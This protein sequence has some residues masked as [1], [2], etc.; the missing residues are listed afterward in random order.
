MAALVSAIADN[1]TEVSQSMD[2]RRASDAV[3]E[4]SSF[5]AT[6]DPADH[7]YSPPYHHKDVDVQSPTELRS[8]EYRQLFRLPAEEVL[9]QDFNCAFQENILLQGHMYL[10]L[11]H[12]CFYSN[13]FGFETKKIIPFHEVTC[14]RRAKTAGIFP[15][16]I[17]IFAGGKKHFF[18]SFLSRDEA[19][20]I[21][22]DGWLQHGNGANEGSEQQDSISETS[23]ENGPIVI[24]NVKS[25][26]QPISNVESVD[27]NK[28]APTLADSKL[29][30]NLEGDVVSTPL[31]E[32]SEVLDNV[33][34]EAVP[35]LISNSS[36]SEKTSIWKQENSDAPKIP[37]YY[38]R[39]AESKFPIKVEEFFSLF[40][41]DEAVIFGDSF[42]KQCGDKD[43]KCTPWYPHE[44]FGHA[45]EVSFQHPI[46]LYFGAKF[47]SCQEVQKFRVYKNSHLIIETSQEIN[48]VPYG[49]Y[50]CVEGLWDVERDGDETKESCVLRVYVNVAFSKRTVWKG[51]IVQSTVEECREAYGT[52]LNI[53]HELLKQKNLEK[54]E[55]DQV[56]L[57]RKK[58]EKA[59]CSESSFEPNTPIPDS[60]EFKRQDSSLL[61]YATPVASLFKESTMKSFASLKSQSHFPLL[62]VITFAVILVMMQLSIVVLLTRPQQVHV[63]SQVDYMN[64]MGSGLN[65]RSSE[66]LA[67][68]EK[69][70]LHL[71]DEM[72]MVETRLEKMRHEHV[73]LKSQMKD[74]ELLIKQIE[75]KR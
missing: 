70:M 13:I 47:G 20:K 52:W 69:R 19:F 54:K 26:N 28:D 75:T 44:K 51:K 46:K 24:E 67:W 63:I 22:N 59:K 21:V 72:F 73:F 45:R 61:Q 49:D 55:E 23:Q 64:R 10:F 58:T 60:K 39:V 15:N 7:S 57:E 74:L 40:F 53:A 18:A 42:H 36:S 62:L 31:S 12:I 33:V 38:T 14:V 16:A 5:S 48:D 27:R 34:E 41:S 29:P 3:S 1:T 32:L 68:M 9:V 30:P 66:A 37:E 8:E 65:E 50:F 11:H 17:E 6:V 4:E 43:F 2:S 56:L 25:P 35:V 71:K